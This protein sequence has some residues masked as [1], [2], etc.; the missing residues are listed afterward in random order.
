[1]PPDQRF[2]P[3]WIGPLAP[4]LHLFVPQT[5]I[6]YLWYARQGWIT[7]QNMMSKAKLKKAHGLMVRH[8]L[9]TKPEKKTQ[10]HHDYLDG[11]VKA[12]TP[13]FWTPKG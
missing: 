8:V 1:M 13:T 7:K 3:V 11:V 2:R 12:V 4:K 10:H 5:S 6:L 9:M